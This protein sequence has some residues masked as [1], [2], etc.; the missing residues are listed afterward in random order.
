MGSNRSVLAVFILIR[1]RA[2][3]SAFAARPD[4]DFLLR[5]FAC[6]AEALRQG[7][8]RVT[9]LRRPSIT[10]P[11]SLHLGSGGAFGSGVGLSALRAAFA[12][13]AN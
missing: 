7:S 4:E 2:F 11:H 5:A 10:T 6:L 8:H 12:H 9:H 13:L 3:C 1:R